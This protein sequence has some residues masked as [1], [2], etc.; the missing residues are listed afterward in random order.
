MA[1]NN[2]GTVLITGANRGIGYEFAKQYAERG[3]QVIACARQP[4]EADALQKLAAE[5]PALHIETL[6]VSDV[7]SIDALATQLASRP[8]DILINNA[9][10][11]GDFVDGGAGGAEL[12]FGHM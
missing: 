7:D 9:G 8:V 12:P 4:D 10:V 5:F 1:D 6:D 11:F 2:Q 3:W